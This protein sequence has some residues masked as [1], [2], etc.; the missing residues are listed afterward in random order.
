MSWQLRESRLSITC[1]LIA[2]LLAVPTHGTCNL[3]HFSEEA[4]IG[5]QSHFGICYA[6]AVTFE[7][8]YR[9]WA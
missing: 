4:S 3:P 9:Q 8:L 7:A 2:A 5:F 1:S 6:L